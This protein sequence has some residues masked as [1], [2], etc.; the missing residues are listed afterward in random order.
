MI[1][2][3]GLERIGHIYTKYTCSYYGT[4]LL[5]YMCYAKYVNFIEFLMDFGIPD[6][7]LDTIATLITDK[8]LLHFNFHN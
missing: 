5:F 3:T 8:K 6:D 2:V 7:I 1:N 4:Y